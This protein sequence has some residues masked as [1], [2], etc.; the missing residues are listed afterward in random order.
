MMFD[1][2]T[3]ELLR[4]APEVPGL[5]SDDLPALLT[6]HYTELA[7]ARLRGAG[8]SDTDDITGQ[9]SLDRIADTYELIASLD[10][11]REARLPSA[12]VAATAQQIVARKELA[13]SPQDEGRANIDRDHV[14][15]AVAATVLFL[16]AEQYADANEAAMAVRIE[17][18]AQLY[19]AT[20]LTENIVD[21]SKGQLASIMGRA[22]RWR[23]ANAQQLTIEE[24]ALAALLETLVAGIELLAAQLL[25]MEA[26]GV[27]GRFGGSQ[28]AFRRVLVLATAGHGRGTLA[29]RKA[30]PA[31]SG[32]HHL[33]S[34]LLAAS[35]SLLKSSLLLVP[36]PTGADPVIWMNWLRF[37]AEKFPYLWPNHR[38]A[39]EKGFHETGVSSVVVLPTGAGKTTVSSLKIAGVLAQKKKVVF[40]APTHALVDQLTEDL[41]EMFPS[42]LFGS[43]VSSDFDLLFMEEAIFQD[44]EVMTPERC[45]TMLSFAPEA[46]EEVGLL[47]FDE[48]H[49][50]NAQGKLRR[51][52]D[53]MLCI[54]G[55]C[56]IVPSADLLLLSAML[57]N[58]EELARWLR[59]LTGRT[60]VAVDL[61]WKPSRQAR[62]V[63]IYNESELAESIANAEQ[64][65]RREN[66]EKKVVQRAFGLQ[67]PANWSPF[68]RRYG[69]YSITG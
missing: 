7:A 65:Q 6:K 12:F 27:A 25:Q 64:V 11:R 69:A 58:G 9:W 3:A 68:L 20:I 37:R 18:D 17:S 50:L 14:D 59:Q 55:F 28:D 15:P 60:S 29:N 45:L 57:N 67:R 39:I 54:L 36:P 46:F 21:L 23:K 22:E 41:Q 35:D 34:L 43:N 13:V 30:V 32:P 48:C 61:V 40:L 4:S 53:G 8:E 56:H 62:G 33:A 26:P 66:R 16:I 5:D 2:V 42:E 47:V 31:Y 63:I 1:A 44:I 49:L 24:R 38:T 51:A 10:E 19:E 52:L